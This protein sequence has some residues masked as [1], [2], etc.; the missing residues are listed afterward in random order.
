M[1]CFFLFG[2]VA[3]A[4]V[5][6]RSS[7]CDGQREVRD[8][9]LDSIKAFVKDRKMQVLTFTGY[10][11]AEYEDPQAMLERASAILDQQDPA[12]TLVNIGA[13][14]SGIGAV[15]EVA[16]EKGFATMGIVSSLARDQDVALSPCVDYVFYVRDTTWGGKLPGTNRL[17]PTSAAI[18]ATGSLFVA[19]GGGDV[20]RDEMLAARRAGKRVTFIPADMNHAI[21]REKAQKKGGPDPSDFRGSAHLALVARG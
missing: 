20:A 11:G 14:A 1:I 5:P 3:L 17:A 7:A 16:K 9:T 2:T 15:Y 12:K 4:V 13:T 6:L 21:A 18:V 8:A 19:I 10:S